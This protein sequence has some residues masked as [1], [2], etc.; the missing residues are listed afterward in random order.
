[1]EVI[2][3]AQGLGLVFILAPAGCAELE[4][5][6]EYRQVVN[7]VRTDSDQSEHD[8]DEYLIADLQV[9]ADYQKRQQEQIGTNIMTGL[10][11]GALTAQLSASTAPTKANWPPME[12]RVIAESW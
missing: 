10:W 9:E 5:L 6:S 2:R 4:S 1:M 7:P 11:V 12:P 8:P 3:K